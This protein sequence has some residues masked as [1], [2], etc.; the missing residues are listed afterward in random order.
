MSSRE[1]EMVTECSGDII[2]DKRFQKLLSEILIRDRG[3]LEDI[4]QL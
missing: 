3:I 2:P 1:E 4:G